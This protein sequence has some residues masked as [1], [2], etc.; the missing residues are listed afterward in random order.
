MRL[1]IFRSRRRGTKRFGLQA[2]ERM[3]D[4]QQTIRNK[5]EATDNAAAGT[6]GLARQ[7]FHRQLSAI[8]HGGLIVKDAHGRMECGGTNGPQGHVTVSD[9]SAYWDIL[10]GGPL[11]A[12]EAYIEGKWTTPDLTSVVRVFSGNPQLMQAMDGGLTRFLRPFLRT[13]HW[14]RRNSRDGSRRN[15]GAHYDLGNEF[16][17]LFLDPTMMYSAGVFAT[18]ATS[19]EEASIA[20]LDLI[21]TKLALNQNDHLLEIGTG[22]GGMA[23]HAAG[24]YGC[25]VTTTTISENQYKMSRERIA[26]AKLSDR[27]TVVKR[28]YRDLEGQYDKLVSV[29]MIEAVGH[30]FMDSYIRTCSE[31]LKPGGRALIQAIVMA[32]RNY[33]WH[34]KTVDFIKKYIFPG[35]C[36]PSI[37]SIMQSVANTSDLQLI[38]LQDIG[39]DYAHTL[40]AWRRAFMSKINQVRD[41]G[42]SEQF[43]RT[44]QYYFSYCEGA[45]LERAIS[46]VQLVFDKPQSR[47]PATR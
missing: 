26:A 7:V 28:D 21:C 38:D 40:R 6:G 30:E 47:L 20:K 46:D 25:R 4:N 23:M 15:I 2:S 3:S 41:L 11:G 34:I 32:D 18:P 17:D 5:L 13:A 37:G 24:N 9:N 1:A 39:V 10:L 31:R 44:W 36:L 27:V 8:S 45:F 43:I 42:Y 16:F 12:S 22:W 19:L 29:E 33:Q 14:L 35:G